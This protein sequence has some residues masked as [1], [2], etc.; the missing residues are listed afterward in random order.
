MCDHPENAGCANAGNSEE[1][2]S[3]PGSGETDANP[4]SEETDPNPG[5]EEANPNP[6]SEETNPNPGN[7]SDED[8]V[9]APA[10][11]TED[12]SDENDIVVPSDKCKSSC[13]I[14]AWAHE[15]D[16][17]KFWRCDGVNAV[18]GTC[19]EG[20]HFNVNTQTCDFICNAGCV[21][22]DIQSTPEHDGLKLFLPWDKV[23][24]TIRRL[25]LT[26]QK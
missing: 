9:E 17:D 10:G 6:G 21:R 16:C 3:N 13:N 2:D 25:Y 22:G 4:G 1:T 7:G 19:S 23:D 8:S 12:G 15:R 18:L 14:G 5:S 24:G 11:S 26:G 20:L